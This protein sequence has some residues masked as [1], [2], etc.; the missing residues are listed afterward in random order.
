MQIVIVVIDEDGCTDNIVLANV[1]T[2]ELLWIPR[3]LYSFY[4]RDRINAA[5]IKGGHSLLINALKKLGFD[6]KYSLCISN[7]ITRKILSNLEV[8]VPVETSAEYYYPLI[9]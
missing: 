4:I 6:V 3:D 2:K 7:Q 9:A 1:A 5:F 8:T